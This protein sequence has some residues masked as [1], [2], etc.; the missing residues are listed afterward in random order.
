MLIMSENLQI[1][2]TSSREEQYKNLLPQLRSLLD[3]ETDLIANCANISAALR[4]AFRFFWV[5]FYF[6]K[7]K[8]LVLGPFQGT[9]AC[10]RIPFGKGVCGMA[11]KEKRAVIVPDVNR[12]EG[13]I[14]CNSESKS[15]IVVPV[16]A[17]GEVIAVLDIDSNFI[18]DFDQTDIIYLEKIVENL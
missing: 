9:I 4:T 8:E 1:L 6:V 10:T 2:C 16:F 12:F 13:H 17:G 5:G 3:G 15:E 7:G 14:A 11:W 18:N